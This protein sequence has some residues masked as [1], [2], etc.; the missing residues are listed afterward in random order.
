MY[1]DIQGWLSNASNK[2]WIPPCFIPNLSAILYKR[3]YVTLQPRLNQFNRWIVLSPRERV[4]HKTLWFKYSLCCWWIDW[5]HTL[6]WYDCQR[7]FFCL[8]PVCSVPRRIVRP[9]M[10]LWDFLRVL[11][12]T[13]KQKGLIKDDKISAKLKLAFF[14]KNKPKRYSQKRIT[15]SLKWRKNNLSPSC[16]MSGIA[17]PMFVQKLTTFLLFQKYIFFTQI[18][19]KLKKDMQ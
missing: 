6:R 16:C 19:Y 12:T 9:R 15:A 2:Q 3:P 1:F 7:C 10:L 8:L 17:I 11:E 4:R 14:Q 13:G 5:V 18:F